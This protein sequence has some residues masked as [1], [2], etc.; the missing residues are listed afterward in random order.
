MRRILCSVEYVGWLDS[1]LE[2]AQME[3]HG[4]GG[5]RNKHMNGSIGVVMK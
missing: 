5:L 4:Q 2:G 1:C 3:D